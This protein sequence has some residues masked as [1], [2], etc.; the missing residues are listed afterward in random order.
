ML[1]LERRLQK[2]EEARAMSLWTEIISDLNREGIRYCV[3]RDI[4][5]DGFAEVASDDEIST[6]NG[7]RRVEVDILVHELDLTTLAKLLEERNF[8]RLRRWGYAPH[9]FFVAYDDQADAW[10]KLDIVT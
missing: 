5:A 6:R 2:A 7:T 1:R 4:P 10:L 9:Q 3:L 8:I